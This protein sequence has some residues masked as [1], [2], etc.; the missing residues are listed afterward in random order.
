MS[1]TPLKSIP[2]L[3]PVESCKYKIEYK[4]GDSTEFVLIG[5]NIAIANN[6]YVLTIST[7]ENDTI[8]IHSNIDSVFTSIRSYGCK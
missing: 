8:E 3:K 6:G 2:S 1:S 7:D 5:F 4:D